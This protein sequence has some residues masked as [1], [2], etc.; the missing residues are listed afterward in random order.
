MMGDSDLIPKRKRRRG[1]RGG[2]NRHKGPRAA[3]AAPK[4][5]V[6]AVSSLRSRL[7]LLASA[8]ALNA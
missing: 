5:P 7:S 4:D 6:Q 3:V 2:K 8:K 1:K